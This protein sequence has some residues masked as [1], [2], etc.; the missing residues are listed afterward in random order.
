MPKPEEKPCEK[1]EPKGPPGYLPPWSPHLAKPP[2]KP[3][4]V[5]IPPRPKVV[6]APQLPPLLP[7]IKPM[8]W[9][10][11]DSPKQQTSEADVY[12]TAP[13]GLNWKGYTP[14]QRFKQSGWEWLPKLGWT[15]ADKWQFKHL[16]ET[17]PG[18]DEQV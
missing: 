4:P 18:V 6:T 17:P 11:T 2:Q 13:P 1:E 5:I 7:S 8:R 16:K 10:F 14:G 15:S 12:W 3:P 9:W